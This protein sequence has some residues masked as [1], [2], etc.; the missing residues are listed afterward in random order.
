MATDEIGLIK[1]TLVEEL[2]GAEQKMLTR[3]ENA[4]KSR[5]VSANEAGQ[6]AAES[7]TGG[8]LGLGAAKLLGASVR[9]VRKKGFRPVGSQAADFWAALANMGFGGSIFAGNAAI[10]TKPVPG[11]VRQAIRTGSAVT[12]F[13][14]FGE[15]ADF[16]ADWVVADRAKTNAALAAAQQAQ[17]AAQQ[18]QQGRK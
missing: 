16:V 17:I 18:A 14:G 2:S 13:Q 9:W 7:M 6:V 5:L 12:F 11:A 1:R 4:I 3:Y 10:K 8:F 15:F